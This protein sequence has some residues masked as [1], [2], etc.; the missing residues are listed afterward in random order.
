MNSQ[1][2]MEPEYILEVRNLKKHF[3]IF[4]KG[5]FQKQINTVKASNDLSFKLK[6]GA[7]LGL[8]G[9]SGCG[10]TTTARTILRALDPTGGDVYFRSRHQGVVNLATLAEKELK[11][12]RKEMQMIFQDPFSSLN[13]RMTV[14]EIVTEPLT[15]HKIGTRQER[16]DKAAD[17]MHK[18]GLKPEHLQRYPHSFSGGQRQR[19]G[20]ARALILEPSLIVCD[21]SVSALDVSVQAQVINLLMDLQVEFGLTYIF[22]AHDLSVVKHICDQ[23]AVMYA[24]SIV[25]M[26]DTQKIFKDPV[27]PYTQGLL[28]AIPHL[29]PD[30]KM[31]CELDGEVL[32]ITKL[33]PGCPFF[34]RCKMATESCRETLPELKI[35]D[36]G[37]Q[38]ACL[39][40]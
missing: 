13:P 29:D 40:I 33:P 7:T 9:E 32:D 12:L 8:V 36:A 21:E 10:K 39:N 37:R 22:V 1:L 5:F 16:L 28:S 19:I 6:E 20:I 2:V 18:V 4:S 27:H 31:T 25:E 11:P 17:L 23:V 35:H 34:S 14:G 24:G 26:G 30:V 38:V 3:P 15:I